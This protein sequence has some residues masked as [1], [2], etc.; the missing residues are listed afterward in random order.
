[1]ITKRKSK[2]YDFEFSSGN[3]HTFE[4]Q[5]RAEMMDEKFLRHMMLEEKEME[6]W[7]P[8]PTLVE[9]FHFLFSAV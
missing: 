6:E 7:N 3:R 9:T 2:K 5:K 1:M 8:G 4:T